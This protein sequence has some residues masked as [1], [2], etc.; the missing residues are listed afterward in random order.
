MKPMSQ[1]GYIGGGALM[2]RKKV[3]VELL[4]EPE[5]LNSAQS[6]QRGG[7]GRRQAMALRW[8]AAEYGA[9]HRERVIARV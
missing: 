2:Q 7:L 5:N 6:R 3:A 9:A 1:V 4:L 8:T